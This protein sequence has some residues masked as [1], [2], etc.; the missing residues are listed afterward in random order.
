MS[1]PKG[2]SLSC[3]VHGP[4]GS[5]SLRARGLKPG[6]F[7]AAFAAV[8][9]KSPTYEPSPTRG[10]FYVGSW[11][12]TLPQKKAEGWGTHFYGLGR[13][14]KGNRR[15]FAPLRMTLQLWGALAGSSLR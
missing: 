9:D 7:V 8:G 2:H 11:F 12:P 1:G 6:A 15:S 10:Q 3:G 14:A 4:E 13:V 5:C